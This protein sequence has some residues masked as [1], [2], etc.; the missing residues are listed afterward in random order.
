MSSFKDDASQLSNDVVQVK[1]EISSQEGSPIPGH[2][3]E[4]HL[5]GLQLG[6]TCETPP[7]EY[8]A[9]NCP[10]ILNS[11]TLVP[12]ADREVDKPN[13][14]LPAHSASESVSSTD[15]HG[16]DGT[17]NQV[18]HLPDDEND[19]S[20]V[21]AT[22]QTKSTEYGKITP[23]P[24]INMNE[25]AIRPS[26]L[27]VSETLQVKVV[28]DVEDTTCA[29]AVDSVGTS[30]VLCCQDGSPSPC[31][32]G[33]G[34]GLLNEQTDNELSIRKASTLPVK[35]VADAEDATC[36]RA[37]DSVKMSD[38]L[39]GQGASSSPSLFGSGARLRSEQ[40]DDMF[41][42]RKAL[43][44]RN[45]VGFMCQNKNGPCPLLALCNLLKLRGDLKM[46][47]DAE[48]VTVELLV[49]HLGELLMNSSPEDERPEIKL[50]YQHN[51]D[52]CFE[53][54]SKL[55]TGIDVNVKFTGVDQM[56][57][58]NEMIVFD[59][60][61]VDVFHGW[62]VDP[63]DKYTAAVIGNSTYNELVEKVVAYREISQRQDAGDIVEG[64]YESLIIQQGI[65]IDEFLRETAS[66]LTVYGI[67][68]LN[69]RMKNGDLAIF[70]RNNHFSTITKHE[71]DIYLLVT[72]QGYLG[73]TIVWERLD[74]IDGSGALFDSGFNLYKPTKRDIVMKNPS[75]APREESDLNKALALSLKDSHPSQ[76]DVECA[77][78]ESDDLDIPP[79]QS[80]PSSHSRKSEKESSGCMIS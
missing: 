71:H 46:N 65:V 6:S 4:G 8:H 18:K 47:A 72:D 29:G 59:L 49:R 23:N 25:E 52:S 9:K 60:L 50:N 62:V 16:D 14:V 15:G 34:T 32:P 55:L 44:R 70:F 73:T 64:S 77:I 19:I 28:V 57:Y 7:T 67:F 69:K 51:L 2:G 48:V 13:L 1:S 66:Q 38:V 39:C 40:A 3:L 53:M 61:R 21:T 76:N 54:H 78:V 68:E 33:S 27:Q 56:E 58:T 20:N 45:V 35:E 42:M 22:M 79:T 5:K 43:F 63:Q 80:A 37:V 36:A 75:L 11:E 10:T 74:D 26:L 12:S 31:L 41:S 30:S 24:L 17:H